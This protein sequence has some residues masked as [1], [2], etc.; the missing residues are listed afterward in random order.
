MCLDFPFPSFCPTSEAQQSFLHC[1]PGET[2]GE[3]EVPKAAQEGLVLV[4]VQLL[5]LT[6][7]IPLITLSP[8]VKQELFTTILVDDPNL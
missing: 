1:L 4:T 7:V 2:Q 3:G 6:W 8:I 5:L